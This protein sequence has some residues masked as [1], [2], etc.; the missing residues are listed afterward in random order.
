[1]IHFLRGISSLAKL[2]EKEKKDFDE[3]EWNGTLLDLHNTLFPS[4]FL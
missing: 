3:M 2:P 1:M 4:Q